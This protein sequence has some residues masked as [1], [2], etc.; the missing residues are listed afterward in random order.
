MSSYGRTRDAPREADS[1]PSTARYPRC[2]MASQPAARHDRMP[3]QRRRE[4]VLDTAIAVVVFACRLRYSPRAA[5]TPTWTRAASMRS[6]LRSLHLPHCRSSR[7]DVLRSASS[8]SP[9][10]RAPR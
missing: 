7:G 6:A 3:R 2:G 1:C 10:P 8:F 5:P 4:L 9:L